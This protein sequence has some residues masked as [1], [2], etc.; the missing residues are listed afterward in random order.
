MKQ[1]IGIYNG[2]CG[3]LNMEYFTGFSYRDGGG[4]DQQV[5]QNL[6]TS[7][8]LCDALVFNDEDSTVNIVFEHI[9][10]THTSFCD[11]H[12]ITDKKLFEAKLKGI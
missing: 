7:K 10:K 11:I 2:D 4:Y 5:L 1:V 3:E 12:A 9:S 8:R 6:S